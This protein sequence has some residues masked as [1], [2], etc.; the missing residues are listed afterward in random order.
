[1]AAVAGAASSL[2]TGIFRSTEW[3]SDSWPS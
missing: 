3:E 2:M 1:V